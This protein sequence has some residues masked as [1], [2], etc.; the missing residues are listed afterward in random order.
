MRAYFCRNNAGRELFRRTTNAR[1]RV[2]TDTP[3]RHDDTLWCDDA[4]FGL[5]FLFFFFSRACLVA[6]LKNS[7]YVHTAA[8]LD[9]WKSIV[10]CHH[11]PRRHDYFVIFV[12]RYSFDIDICLFSIS[13]VCFSNSLV[14]VCTNDSAAKPSGG[15]TSQRRC[16]VI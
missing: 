15:A 9:I 16:K 12:T 2:S 7:E 11:I 5:K 10:L 4:F 13:V 14:F 6:I 8:R 1:S 3:A